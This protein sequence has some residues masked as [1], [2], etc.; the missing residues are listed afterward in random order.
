MG[1]YPLMTKRILK[2]LKE[3]CLKNSVVK[4]V[5]EKRLYIA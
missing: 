4:N 5:I 2:K 1:G 3:T